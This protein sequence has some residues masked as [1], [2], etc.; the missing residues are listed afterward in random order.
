MLEASI[1]NVTG[2]PELATAV[3]VYVAPPTVPDAGGV[4]VKLIDCELADAAVTV[5]DCCAC[6]AGRY[7][8]FPA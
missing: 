2:S 3:T 1:A 4:E 7:A 6:A 5:N 8:A